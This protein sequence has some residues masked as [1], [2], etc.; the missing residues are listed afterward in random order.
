M[1]QVVTCLLVPQIAARF[2]SQSLFNAGLAF[3]AAAAL[4]ALLVAPPAMFPALV[5]LQG[6]GQGGLFALAMTVIILRSPDPRAAARLSGMSQAL[7]Y[8]LAAFGPMLVGM[9]HSFTGSYA[10]TGWLFAGIG[11]A[12]M[13]SGWGAGR[14]LLVR[15]RLRES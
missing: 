2:R 6:I 9:L 5:L 7:G 10:V 8:V 13:A 14:P 4:L 3:V 11:L 12:A 1:V 15:P